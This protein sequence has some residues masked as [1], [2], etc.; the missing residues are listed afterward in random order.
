ML[1]NAMKYNLIK[2]PKKT[3]ND[4]LQTLNNDELQNIFSSSYFYDVKMPDLM[5]KLQNEMQKRKLAA[6]AVLF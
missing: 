6:Q 5:K 2:G 3:V 4:Y 1:M